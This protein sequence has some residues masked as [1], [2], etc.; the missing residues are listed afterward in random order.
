MCDLN[1]WRVRAFVAS[2]LIVVPFLRF[3]VRKQYGFLHPEVLAAVLLL[4]LVCALLSLFRGVAFQLLIAFLATVMATYPALQLAG[5]PAFLPPWLCAVLTFSLTLLAARAMREKFIPVL[6][7]FAWSG[8][9][10]DAALAV[11]RTSVTAEVRD[12][13]A[14]GH[15]LWLILD[16]QVGLEGFPGGFPECVR[17]RNR[18]Q[19]VLD[20]H[21]F[22]TFPGAYSNYPT[23]VDSVASIL[24]GR[25]ARRPGELMPRA[26][27]GHMRHY[28]IRENR[29]FSHYLERG[30]RVMAWQHGA[31]RICG[32]S[33]PGI[34]CKDYDE[35]IKW[36]PSA[37]ARWPERFRW[38]VGSYQSTDPLLVAVKGFFPFRFGIKLSGPL[39]LEGLWPQEL[40]S[41][42][43]SEPHK[44]LFFAHL[45]TPHSP[46]LLREDGSIRPMAEWAEDRADHLLSEAVYRDTYCR[47]CEQSGFV[48]S[49]VDRLLLQLDESELLDS[50]TVVIHGD[51]G[52]RILLATGRGGG[53]RGSVS[54]ALLDF[55]GEPGGRGLIDRFSTLL[56]IKR[57]GVR[58]PA[59]VNERHSVLTL[60]SR[61]VFKREP[62]DGAERADKVY[63]T[64]AREQFHSVDIQNDW[65]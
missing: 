44:T 14:K 63:L 33:S 35:Q 64:D 31:I 13:A 43:R 22:T 65:R 61:V 26:G 19:A 59:T 20:R 30:Y 6:A 40:V 57:P 45:L 34:E 51:H 15:V 37:P 48:A 47:Y 27:S 56:A 5:Y 53:S 7:V 10:A 36:L 9:L 55:V 54:P 39:C 8:L 49:Q 11:K 41:R 42:I 4:V 21:G 58:L 32:Q 17:A 24:N 28:A 1:D 46:Y 18:F 52:T 38:L 3:V 50:M 62:E 12:A 2:C 60:L 23:T 25:L 16:E 29:L